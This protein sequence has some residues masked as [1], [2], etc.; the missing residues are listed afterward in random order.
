MEVMPWLGSGS[1]SKK[2]KTAVGIEFA[3]EEGLDEWE[4]LAMRIIEQAMVDYAKAWK[5]LARIK[6]LPADFSKWSD[7]DYRMAYY[8]LND[9]KTIYEIE[10]FLKSNWFAF[11][12]SE[13]DPDLIRTTLQNKCKATYGALIGN[14][15]IRK[16]NAILKGWLTTNAPYKRKGLRNG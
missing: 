1:M 10:R 13:L 5:Y 8:H 14:D 9:I 12:Y 11:L 6:K 4:V 16:I 3:T 7:K 2:A 15:R